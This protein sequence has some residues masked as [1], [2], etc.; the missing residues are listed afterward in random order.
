MS[1]NRLSH[2][3][4]DDADDDVIVG[5]FDDISQIELDKDDE[6]ATILN[7]IGSDTDDVTY[8]LNIYRIPVTGKKI[9]LYEC[10]PSSPQKEKLRDEYGGGKFE[11]WLRKNNRI[12]ARPKVLIEAPKNLNINKNVQHENNT[13]QADIIGL[14]EQSQT[15]MLEGIAKLIQPLAQTTTAQSQVSQM[16]EMLALMKAMQGFSPPPP[17]VTDPFESIKK[18]MELKKLFGGSGEGE[19]SNADVLISAIEYIGAPLTEL[20]KRAHASQS[21]NTL[22]LENK[23]K[24]K[25]KNEDKKLLALKMGVQMMVGAAEKDNDPAPY[26]DIILDRLGKDEIKKF[27]T[28]PDALKLLITINPKVEKYAKWFKELSVLI[29]ERIG[30]NKI[31]KK[32]KTN[33]K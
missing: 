18:V 28:D 26:V 30:N 4:D 16:S 22:P 11:F 6:L 10:D 24:N 27:I 19:T 32:K 8:S 14:I 12:F 15:N 31:K 3:D 17:V 20:T 7:E 9:W 5:K 2:N 21:K 29:N 33:K 25:Q 23:N 13:N 1:S